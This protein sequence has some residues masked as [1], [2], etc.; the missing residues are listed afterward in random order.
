MDAGEQ[1]IQVVDL[2]SR[3]VQTLP[4]DGAST[5]PPSLPTETLYVSGGNT[6]TLFVYT[7]NYGAATLPEGST[8][9]APA[10]S[11]DGSGFSSPK[12]AM[13]LLLF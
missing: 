10:I 11:T 4:R 7:W 5:A 1:R 8:P 2:K 6:D 13:A 3:R 12:P 9:N